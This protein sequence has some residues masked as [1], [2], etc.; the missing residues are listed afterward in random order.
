MRA[1]RALERHR[2]D[3]NHYD[4]KPTLH[5]FKGGELNKNMKTMESFVSRFQLD[6]PIRRK[7]QMLTLALLGSHVHRSTPWTSERH[8]S[9]LGVDL[10]LD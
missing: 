5:V 3:F 2:P 4:L 9:T 7:G 8:I 6:W 1:E 10:T